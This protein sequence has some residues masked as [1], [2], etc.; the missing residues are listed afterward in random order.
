[1]QEALTYGRNIHTICRK[2]SSTGESSAQRAGSFLPQ[3]KT[4]RSV[5][6]AFSHRRNLRAMCRKLSATGE[7]SAQC[8][9]SFPS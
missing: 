1:M 7:T 5:Q 3:E 6:E 8:A 2:L 4:P 9:G